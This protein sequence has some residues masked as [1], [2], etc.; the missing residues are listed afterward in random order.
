[1]INNSVLSNLGLLNASSCFL[2]GHLF[3]LLILKLIEEKI[4]QLEK[5][6]EIEFARLAAE[7]KQITADTEIEM[8]RTESVQ[9]QVVK[10]REARLAEIEGDL[11][12]ISLNDCLN[13][14]ADLHA[15]HVVT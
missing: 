6:R 9:R 13:Y 7:K 11:V 3:L 2:S 15:Q 10:D 5:D 14:S 1:M 8:A 12:K 4:A